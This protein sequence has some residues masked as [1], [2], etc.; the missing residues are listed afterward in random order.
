MKALIKKLQSVGLVT[1]LF[2]IIGNCALA[3]PS[4]NVTVA[5]DGSG[6]YTTVQAAIDA[7]PTAQ[8]TSYR[9]F[10]KNGTYKEVI[11]VPSN[12]PF[13]Q[14]IGESVSKTI[15]T[16]DNYS[17]KAIPSGGTYG[18]ST[19]A[20]VTIKATDFS[21]VDITFE[22]TTGEAPQALAIN[23]NN[24]RASFKNCRF[25]GGQD[26]LL[27]NNNGLRQYYLNC[28]IDGTVDFIFGN[29]RAVFDYCVIYPKDR[30]SSGGSYITA[31]NTKSPEPYGFVF[32]N[33]QITANTGSTL[34]VLGRPWQND[35]NTT[36]DAD[37]SRNQTVFLNTIMG[38]SV[39]PVGWATWDAGTNTAYINYAE[40]N[41]KNPNNTPLDV[42]Q[43]VAWSKQLNST[44]AVVYSDA[45]LFAGWDPTAVFLDG[46][47]YTAPLVVSNFRGTKGST[48]TPFKWNLSWP[49]SGVQYDVYRS[50]DN[51]ANFTIVNTQTSADEN[52]NFNY[53][54]NNPPANQSYQYYIKASKA[55]YTDYN[56]DVITI[57]SIPTITVNG[58]LSAFLQGL[59]TPSNSQSY[60][61]SAVDL[62]SNLVITPPTG[63]QISQDGGT[64]WTDLNSPIHLTPT[65]GK[66]ASTT[67]T[68]RLNS[69]TVATYNGDISHTSTNAVT[70]N[71]PLTGTVQTEPLK[72]S[73]KLINWPLTADNVATNVATGITA[74]TPTLNGLTLSNGTYNVNFPAYSATHGQSFGVSADG[75]SWGT[76]KGGPG[77]LNR[78]FYEEFSIKPSAGYLLR[79]DTI[80]F[81]TSLTLTSGSFAVSYSLN[82]FA[83]TVDVNS[84]I[85]PTGNSIT[86]NTNGTFTGTAID[87]IREDATNISTFKFPVTD[88][89][90]GVGQTL[91]IRLYF[92]TGSSSDGRYVKIK[93][94]IVKGEATNTLPLDLLSFTAKLDQRISTQVNLI[95]Q[96]TNEINTSKFE[97]ERSADGQTFQQIKI[98]AT[99]NTSGNHTYNFTDENPLQGLTYYRLKQIDINGDYKYS[100]LQ[101]IN[102]QAE[103]SL[104]VYPN[105][106]ANILTVNHPQAGQNSTIQIVNV[107]GKTVKIIQVDISSFKTTTDVSTLPSGLYILHLSNGNN[108]SVLKFIKL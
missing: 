85:A 58:T 68:V 23:V 31:A 80:S 69:T 61:V 56:S 25:L 72:V 40:Y 41:S 66:V 36:V 22:N 53:T 104:N 106:V 20:T 64:N 17:G 98:I 94:F 43:R 84:G 96:T 14:L 16:Y 108:Q 19:S 103:G 78:S 77:N 55:G 11:E 93:D 54:D 4:Y 45:N 38:A 12:K 9:I 13:M 15:I 47:T 60:T 29:A 70:V 67:I 74:T 62:V 35:S 3:D 33:S 39:N 57:S 63:Y 50:T 24:D 65:D 87:M 7:A 91:K 100:K 59:G 44:E 26:T 46:A 8:T 49:M 28:Y 88:L 37:K 6:D 92:R 2:L 81:N 71:Q 21:A 97:V 105:P 89:N 86:F 95:W 83:T 73:L 27:A 48:T 10:I 34:Y 32:R 90:V 5:K 18:T 101:V 102:N 1:L 79:I 52:V 76:S 30:S 82:D 51:G 75:G 42:S 99:K 107:N